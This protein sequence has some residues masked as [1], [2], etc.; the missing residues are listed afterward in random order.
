MASFGLSYF[1]PHMTLL[2][3]LQVDYLW[4]NEFLGGQFS[5]ICENYFWQKNILSQIPYFYFYFKFPAKKYLI[6][7]S[8][9]L[10][11]K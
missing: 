10:P 6:F 4:V 11:T 3:L 5:P 7:R 9:Q 2:L 8:P 1:I